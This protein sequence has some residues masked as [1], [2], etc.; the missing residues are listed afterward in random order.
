MVCMKTESFDLIF[1]KVIKVSIL[2]FIYYDHLCKISIY[3]CS[4]I[5]W[6]KISFSFVVVCLLGWPSVRPRLWC[7]KQPSEIWA[8][9]AA[10]CFSA[11]RIRVWSE[12]FVFIWHAVLQRVRSIVDNTNLWNLKSIIHALN[13]WKAMVLVKRLWLGLLLATAIFVL[14]CTIFFQLQDRVFPSLEWL[15]MTKSV[16]WNFTIIQ[17]LAFLSNPKNPDV[18]SNFCLRNMVHLKLFFYTWRSRNSTIFIFACITKGSQLF[19]RIITRSKANSYFK[20]RS[21]SGNVL[22]PK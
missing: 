14:N 19:Q 17:V 22:P 18:S 12:I 20:S 9:T 21:Y 13:I 5:T 8:I 4:R 10:G 3:L 16:L 2:N 1:M 7:H 11:D 6:W 15:Q